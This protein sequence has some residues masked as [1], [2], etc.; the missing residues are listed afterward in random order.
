MERLNKL[1]KII[2]YIPIV[3]NFKNILDFIV[4]K[5]SNA[6]QRG[7]KAQNSEPT[8]KSAKKVWVDFAQNKSDK[9]IAALIFVPVISNITLLILNRKR[10]PPESAPSSTLNVEAKEEKE[11]LPNKVQQKRKVHFDPKLKSDPPESEPRVL[12]KPTEF[13]EGTSDKKPSERFDYKSKKK[14]KAILS[15]NRQRRSSAIQPKETIDVEE[16]T[17]LLR[18][19]Q[20]AMRLNLVQAALL[21]DCYWRVVDELKEIPES[22]DLIFSK[23]IDFLDQKN[24]IEEEFGENSVNADPQGFIS[25][26]LLLKTEDQERLREKW[27]LGEIR[28]VTFEVFNKTARGPQ[29]ASQWDLLTKKLEALCKYPPF[30]EELQKDIIKFHRTKA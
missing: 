6:G 14:R 5:T 2:D 22:S 4:K 26:L 16:C 3:S 1:H 9:K 24:V 7:L 19:M 18:Y 27:K 23:M 10:K 20:K 8:E 28:E 25:R 12:G 17:P 30:L 13:F 11:E 15:A 29:N 21:E